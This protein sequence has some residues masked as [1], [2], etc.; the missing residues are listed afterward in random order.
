MVNYEHRRDVVMQKL[1]T[2]LKTCKEEGIKYDKEKLI[3]Q[4]GF[5]N[6]VARRTAMDYIKRA[7]AQ[8]QHEQE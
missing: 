8:F 4:L 2:T 1:M 7:E 6:Q 5:E 3:L